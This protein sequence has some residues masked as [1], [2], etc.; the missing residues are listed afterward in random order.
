M[1]RRLLLVVLV[2]VFYFVVLSF[3]WYRLPLLLFSFLCMLLMLLI[4]LS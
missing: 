4:A 2:I 3:T 1:I